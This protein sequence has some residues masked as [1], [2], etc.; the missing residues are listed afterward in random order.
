MSK[1]KQFSLRDKLGAI[2]RVKSGESRVKV[3]TD[4]GLTEST[5]RTWLSNEAKLRTFLVDIDS[6]EGLSRKRRRLG[7]DTDL[8]A[9]V[10]TWFVQARQNGIPI[11]GPIIKA[12]AEKF[13]KDLGSD[14]EFKA[15]DG[16]LYRFQKRH[17]ISQV[18]ISGEARSGDQEA[19]LVFHD[20]LRTVIA[21]GGYTEDQV[22]NVDETALYFKML[23]EKS[24]S[25]KNDTN[26][27]A[28]FKQ[29][30]NRLT[31][32][33]CANR[34]G[35]HKLK[36]LCIG[37]YAKPRCFHHVN[38]DNL[39]LSYANSKNAWMTR[40]IF[41]TWFNK[42]FIPAVRQHMRSTG[43]DKKA[44]LLMDQ[45]PA[46]PPAES[47]VSSDGKITVMFL[48][49]NTTAHIQP[50]DQGI[51]KCFKSNY[52]RELLL[53][54]IAS[55]A[56]VPTFVKQITVKD[57]IYTC[58][59]AWDNV[60]PKTVNNCWTKGLGQAFQPRVLPAVTDAD[61]FPGFTDSDVTETENSLRAR[62]FDVDLSPANLDAWSSIDDDVP[63]S[64][65][66][67]D[68]EI[69]A[70][71]QSTPD[72]D[73]EPEEDSLPEPLPH[74][75]SVIEGLENAQRWLESQSDC[76]YVVLSAIRLATD[77][78][79]RKKHSMARA[80]TQQKLTDFFVTR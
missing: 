58:G 11:S 61:D 33:L 5:L 62:G 54:A 73:S 67:T 47:L 9:A 39:P 28:G 45:C 44:L 32:M 65:L 41:Q 74:V 70:S 78:T 52:R 17:A 20:E 71:V 60:T 48:P 55:P 75:D 18:T 30:K 49:K 12:Q 4:L 24:L 59:R 56:D 53:S 27:T 37:H 3:R 23:P 40:D 51:I 31:L 2:D 15:S 35:T 16:W 77:F 34:T 69:V 7:Q 19:A 50:L 29:L 36:P 57:A 25:V 1:R 76:S 42:Q 26:K 38:T 8:D 46:H 79:I 22:Y 14:T 21:N 63:T 64:H 6:D 80:K 43:Q 10:Y 13:H 66:L 72:P 68:S